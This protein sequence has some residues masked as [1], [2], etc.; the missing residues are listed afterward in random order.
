MAETRFFGLPPGTYILW[1]GNRP[2]PV[3]TDPATMSSAERESACNGIGTFIASNVS[4][5]KRHDGHYDAEI[6]LT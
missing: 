5:R 3:T 2:V 6:E 4:L 1:C